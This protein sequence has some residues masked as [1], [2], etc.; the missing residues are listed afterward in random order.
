MAIILAVTHSAPE[1][2]NLDRYRNELAAALLGIPANKANIQGLLALRKLVATAPDRDSEVAFLPQLRAVNVVKACQQWVT[3]DED[4][5]EE[6]ES[7]MALV[8]THLAPILQNVPGGHWEFMF[9]VV[10]SNLEVFTYTF[11]LQIR[12][13]LNSGSGC[14]GH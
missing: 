4:I 11:F 9:D 6:V 10:E 8:F 13:G 5:D 2:P 14:F 3:S 1:P 12:G 7:T